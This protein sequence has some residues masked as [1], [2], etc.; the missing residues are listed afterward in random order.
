MSSRLQSAF[1]GSPASRQDGLSS[2]ERNRNSINLRSLTRFSQRGVHTT[3]V[4]NATHIV[5]PS[6]ELDNATRQQ[7]QEEQEGGLWGWTVVLGSSVIFFV[8]LG[9]I[10]SFGILQAELIA[11]HY[12]SASTLGWVSSTTVVLNP[13][14]ALPITILIRNTSNRFVAFLGAL[15]TGLGYIATSYTFSRPVVYLFLAQSLFG[16]GYALNFWSCNSLA[17]E[18]FKRKRALAI[19]IVYAG[20]GLG[21]A[22]FSIGLSKLIDNVGLTLGVRI[23]GIIALAILI[24]ASF[25]LK[26]KTQTRIP[27]FKLAYFRQTNFNLLIFATALMTFSLFVPPFYLPSYAVSAGMTA[28]TGAYLVAGFNLASFIGRIVF[29]FMADSRV[30]PLTS[31]CLAMILMGISILTIWIASS[32]SL[33]P[34][35]LFLLVN[36]AASGALLSLQ[37]PA[38]ASLYGVS[39]MPSTMAIVSM[40]RAAG[41]AFGAPLAGILL[42]DFGDAKVGVKAF[43]IPLLVMGFISLFAASALLLL[44]FRIG[45]VDLRKKV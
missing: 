34:L 29:G 9:L 38:L 28:Q 24:P 44:R 7:D 14:L 40:S 17:G 18:Y 2:S 23:A 19:G 20:S 3:V 5:D 8:T 37:A 41:S 22:V 30:G 43:T 26:K 15:C 31:L 16:L 21:G 32:G 36:G 13:L 39:E 45:G 11:R 33:G 42:D 25:T 35:I 1:Q 4:S 6:N 12:A 10:Y 27:Q